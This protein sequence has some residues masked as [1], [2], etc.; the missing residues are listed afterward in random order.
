MTEWSFNEKTQGFGW[1]LQNKYAGKAEILNEGKAGYTSSALKQDFDRVIRRATAPA[2]APTL[3]FTIFL[4][5]N[6]AC[7]IGSS[8]YVPWPL[9]SANIRAFIDAILSYHVLSNTKIVLITPPPIAGPAPMVEKTMTKDEIEVA[10]RWKKEGPRYKT[11]MS[12]KRYA[13]GIMHIAGEYEEAG[14]VVALNFWRDIVDAVLEEEGGTYDEETPPGCG[15]VG[16]KA[17]PTGWFTDGLHLN[18]KGYNVLSKGLIELLTKK[19]PELAPES[20]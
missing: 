6:D 18:V 7:I 8:E 11:Y 3:L 2:A 13:E 9:F 1:F 14:R 16:A 15:L 5:A 17:F 10:N 20:L 12:K 19:W 4:G